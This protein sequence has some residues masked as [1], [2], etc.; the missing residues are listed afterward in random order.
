MAVHAA[1]VPKVREITTSELDA[2][3]VLCK[4]SSCVCERDCFLVLCVHG[5]QLLVVSC[6]QGRGTGLSS[7]QPFT[8]VVHCWNTKTWECTRRV[9]PR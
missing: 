6:F 5:R 7:K 3:S 4:Q 9:S 1:G 8:V 2:L